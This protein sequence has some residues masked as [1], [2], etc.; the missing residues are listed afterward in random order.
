ML[1]VKD[2]CT[3]G[4]MIIHLN[5]P[6]LQYFFSYGE[7]KS[8]GMSSKERCFHQMFMQSLINLEPI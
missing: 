8:R 6:N 4:S 1:K 2:T 3:P 7:D 5:Y